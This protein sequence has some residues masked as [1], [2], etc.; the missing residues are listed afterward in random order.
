MIADAGMV[1]THAQ[2]I[3]AATPQRTLPGRFTA[4]TPTPTMAPV[5]VCVVETLRARR[6]AYADRRSAWRPA[7]RAADPSALRRPSLRNHYTQRSARGLRCEGRMGHAAEL[8]AAPARADG[9]ARRRPELTTPHRTLSAHWPAFVEQAEEAGWLPSF[10]MREVQDYLRCGLPEHGCAL[11]VCLDCGRGVLVAFSCKHRGFCPSCC[12]RRMSDAALHLTERVLP[13]VPL[14][15]WVCSL[16]FQLR[17]LLGYDRELCAAVLNAFVKELSRSYRRRAKEVHGL[18]SIALA[19]TGAVTVVQRTDSALRLSVH[20]HTIAVD[21]VYASD[22]ADGGAPRFLP[23]PEPSAAEAQE[24][25]ERVAA[26]ID[27]LRDTRRGERV[28]RKHG[29]YVDEHDGGDAEQEAPPAEQAALHA[30]YEAS[31]RGQQLLGASAG[32]PVLRLLGAAPPSA[33]GEERGVV[34]EARGVNTPSGVTKRVVHASASVHGRDKKQLERLCRYL[35]RPPLAQ[36]RLHELPDGRL[37]LSLRKAF[38]DGTTSV[39]FE[40]LDFIARLVAAIPPP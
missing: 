39:V 2:G 38:R 1:K 19:Q 5:I 3:R 10:V 27:A 31:A 26:R 24:L 21:G 4:P 35:M 28:L 14:R 37:Q 22:A 11:L 7:Q 13:E 20:F 12:G 16:P 8:C 34:G 23:L 36:E 29:R 33:A 40:P 15:H 9:Y 32:K 25:A 18:S 17:Y 30:C 6:R